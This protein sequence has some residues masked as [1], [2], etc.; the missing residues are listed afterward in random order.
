MNAKRKQKEDADKEEGRQE[1]QE[2]MNSKD[3][4]EEEGE[5]EEE[6]ERA[7]E[8]NISQ[9][10]KI[11]P[12]PIDLINSNNN[13]NSSPGIEPTLNSQ[14]FNTPNNNN[15]QEIAVII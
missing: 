10:H 13:Y 15:T 8:N 4:K 7:G 12:D 6:E 1:E 9:Q 14:I 11:I 3:Q 5:E 2:H